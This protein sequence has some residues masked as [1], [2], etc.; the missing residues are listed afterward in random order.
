[1]RS[2]IVDEFVKTGNIIASLP[3]DLTD[4]Q[5][6]EVERVHEILKLK[7]KAEKSRRDQRESRLDRL[8]S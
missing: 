6:A 7:L 3:K 5:L 2:W 8:D 1:M 4:Q